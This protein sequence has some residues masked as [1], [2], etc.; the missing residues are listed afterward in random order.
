MIR[1]RRRF[2]D[3][4]ARQLALFERDHADLIAAC[5]AARRRYDA[6][7]RDE[8][9]EH[10]GEYLDLVAEGTAALADRRNHYAA[11]MDRAAAEHYTAEFNRAV[12][13]RLAPFA[14]ELDE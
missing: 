1:F 9:E 6:A 4:I 14:L 11:A 13:R 2:G 8:A 12:K 3:V 7:D 5:V 10:Y